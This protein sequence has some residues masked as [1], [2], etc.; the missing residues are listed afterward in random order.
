MNM[1]LSGIT[2]GLT[3]IASGAIEGADLYKN[4]KGSNINKDVFKN[5]TQ[6][7]KDLLYNQQAIMSLGSMGYNSPFRIKIPQ[8]P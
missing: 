5:M 8:N 1:A 4:K 3:N 6:E 7:Q 2:S